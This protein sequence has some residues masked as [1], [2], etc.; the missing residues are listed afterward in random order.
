MKRIAFLRAVCSLII[1]AM[2]LHG[3]AHARAVKAGKPLPGIILV[4]N[5]P[6]MLL[7]WDPKSPLAYQLLPRTRVEVVAAYDS[8]AGPVGG[9]P[10]AV[11]IVESGST[12]LQ[13]D[14]ARHLR[15]PPTGP[16]CLRLRYGRNQSIPLRLPKGDE[17]SDGFR[18]PR[19]EKSVAAA[20]RIADLEREKARLVAAIS[21]L[22]G[23]KSPFERWRAEE[24]LA[25]AAACET[26]RPKAQSQPPP[27]AITGSAQGPAAQYQCVGLFS[28]F[29]QYGIGRPGIDARAFASE[30][31][32][33]LRREKAVTAAGSRNLK[34]LD[35]RIAQTEQLLQAIAAHPEATGRGF[36]P[37][38]QHNGL[39]LTSESRDLFVRN[40]GK[41]DAVA[42]SG[43]L[44]A[45]GSCVSEARSQF[46]LAYQ[47]WRASV[48]PAL[49]EKRAELDR[50]DCRARYAAE[51][52]RQRELTSRLE[53]LTEVQGKLQQVGEVPDIPR[54][55][56]ASLVPNGCGGG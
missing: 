13:F 34:T 17:S 51:G 10:I 19:W 27:T 49:L 44:D 28:M 6:S 23:M 37:L 26:I 5:G 25:D 8:A 29:V 46:E 16:I 21:A 15:N 24:G 22:E 18:H 32:A 55:A 9:E 40:A 56:P 50:K 38:L 1:P 43:V 52:E 36:K 39:S 35:E 45:Y 20:S 4:T 47:N 48:N 3:S 42:A 53:L 11:A 12:E 2:A 54:L 14:L 41:P 33:A 30:M 31:S 7:S